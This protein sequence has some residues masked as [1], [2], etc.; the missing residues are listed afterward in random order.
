MAPPDELSIRPAARADLRGILELYGSAGLDTGRKASLAKARHIFSRMKSYP[1]YTVYVAA[2]GTRLAGTFAL[3]I[4]DNLAN[5]GAPSGIVEDVAVAQDCQGQGIGR[6]MMDFARERCR[7]RGC[8]KLVLSSNRKRVKAHRFYESLGYA[9]HGYSFSLDV[10][11]WLN[12]R[13]I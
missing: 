12:R 11:S 5:G 9:Q 7:K 13:D 10:P 2:Q 6:K 8:Y 1:D 3:L 4:M